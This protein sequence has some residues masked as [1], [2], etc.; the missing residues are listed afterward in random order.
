MMLLHDTMDAHAAWSKHMQRGQSFI[1]SQFWHSKWCRLQSLTHRIGSTMIAFAGKLPMLAI[2]V[3]RLNTDD[4]NFVSTTYISTCGHVFLVMFC[5]SNGDIGRSMTS[6]A[7]EQNVIHWVLFCG[8][9]VHYQY[10]T[11]ED[12]RC[13]M[14]VRMM[15]GCYDIRRLE[16]MHANWN[17]FIF[18]VNSFSKVHVVGYRAKCG[19]H[20][21][22]SRDH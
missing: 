20:L 7:S 13:S 3:W 2:A 18:I 8:F 5:L 1:R 16:Y 11:N 14:S 12:I 19:S 21:H 9:C 6:G 4:S 15:P 22:L 10:V 17:N